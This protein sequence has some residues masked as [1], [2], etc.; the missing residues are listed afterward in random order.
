MDIYV[1][2]HPENQHNGAQNFL[3]SGNFHF[4]KILMP[5]INTQQCNIFRHYK[6]FH[7]LMWEVSTQFIIHNSSY[8]HKRND[9]SNWTW[10]IKQ[11]I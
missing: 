6:N 9:E 3:K 1:L 7:L 4:R 5:E 10:M 11:Q 2:K 8:E